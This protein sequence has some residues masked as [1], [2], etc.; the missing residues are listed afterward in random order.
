MPQPLGPA[1]LPGFSN[2]RRLNP[3]LSSRAP[4]C[5]EILSS[6]NDNAL[7]D[8]ALTLELEEPAT[9]TRVLTQ[10]YLDLISLPLLTAR[11]T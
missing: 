11:L 9:P 7:R 1:G 2:L 3:T 5:K 4:R 8:Y 10:K 6:E